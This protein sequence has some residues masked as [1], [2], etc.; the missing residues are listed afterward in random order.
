MPPVDNLSTFIYRVSQRSMMQ[1]TSLKPTSG[2]LRWHG[3]PPPMRVGDHLA[4]DF[5]NSIAAPRGTS[6]EWLGSGHNLLAW[7]TNAGALDAASAQR[8]ASFKPSSRLEEV[9]VEAKALREFFRDLVARMRVGG[10]KAVSVEDIERLNALLERDSRFDQ[11]ELDQDGQCF[12]LVTDRPWREPAE[13]L[14]LIAAAM[15]DFICNID[16]D[17]VRKCEA[18]ECTLWFLDRTKG[19]RRRWCSQAVCGNRAKAA[20]HR[21]RRKATGEG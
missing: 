10:R 5:L 16:L 1:A 3:L 6:I 21:Q 4:L 18:P 11:I 17:L 8:L 15:A 14:M 7:L 9:A 2:I 20:A 19:H 13:L 12:L